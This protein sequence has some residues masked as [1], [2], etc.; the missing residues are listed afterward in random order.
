M[1][2]DRLPK[3]RTS[4]SPT[5]HPYMTGPWTPLH[6]EVTAEDETEG[7][8]DAHR[9][10]VAAGGDEP[11]RVLHHAQVGEHDVHRVA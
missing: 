8:R 3:V 9:D 10:R 4:L 2:L 6:E 11:T 1:K 5:N 7:E